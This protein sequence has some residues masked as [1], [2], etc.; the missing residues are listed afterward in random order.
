MRRH[1]GHREGRLPTA[2]RQSSVCRHDSMAARSQALRVFSFGFT[3]R[4]HGFLERL[5]CVKN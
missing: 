4:K 2:A 3:E 1:F 5:K